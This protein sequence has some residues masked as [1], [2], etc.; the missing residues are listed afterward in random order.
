[1]KSKFVAGQVLEDQWG[2]EVARIVF[3]N[4]IWSSDQDKDLFLE[5]Y[6]DLP[7]EDSVILY[8]YACYEEFFEGEY[9]IR[10]FIRENSLIN[11]AERE[12]KD[13]ERQHIVDALTAMGVDTADLIVS[14]G[15][16]YI[17]SDECSDYI[18]GTHAWCSSSMSC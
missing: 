8:E 14:E 3:A 1:M 5:E 12:E 11:V 15:R 7:E 10:N 18:Q 17:G 4:G 13:R 6:N 16:V 9:S 2:D